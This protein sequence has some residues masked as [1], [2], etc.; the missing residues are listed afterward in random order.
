MLSR[1]AVRV[2]FLAAALG[3]LFHSGG[4]SQAQES[5]AKAAPQQPP[6]SDTMQRL[7]LQ[8]QQ[9]QSAVQQ[10][11]DEAQNYRSE[12]QELK[13]ELQ[14]T[15]DKLNSAERAQHQPSGNVQT[16]PDAQPADGDQRV[17]ERIARLE[18]D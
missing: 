7:E 3:I 2:Y 1:K 6:S 10:L 15:L 14:I 18:E 4:R 5:P 16:S 12:T 8:I 9:L 11:R 17:Q 13:R